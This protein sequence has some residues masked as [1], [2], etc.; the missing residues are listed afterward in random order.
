[1]QIDQLA[2]ERALLDRILD[3]SSDDEDTARDVA[4][5]EET[6]QLRE[7]RVEEL[8][9]RVRAA[10]AAFT[11]LRRLPPELREYVSEWL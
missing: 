6:I 9:D 5:M 2:W 8:R 7:A 4:E 3:D 11:A 10:R 1:M